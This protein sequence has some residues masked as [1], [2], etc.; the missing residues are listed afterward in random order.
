MRT[1][2]L[3]VFG[4]VIVPLTAFAGVVVSQAVQV[5]SSVS[6]W[7]QEQMAADERFLRLQEPRLL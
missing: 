5:S 2:F 7:V 3:V 6:P 1:D 4:L